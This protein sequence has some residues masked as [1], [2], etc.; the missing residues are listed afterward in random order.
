MERK[1][2]AAKSLLMRLNRGKAN[3]VTNGT[4]LDCIGILFTSSLGRFF[5]VRQV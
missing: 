2:L 3:A 4:E 5:I 1:L